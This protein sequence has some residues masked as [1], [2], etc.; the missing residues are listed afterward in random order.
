M[1]VTTEQGL[2]YHFLRTG[3]D[4]PG[5]QDMQNG[6][7][8]AVSTNKAALERVYSEQFA[9]NLHSIKWLNPSKLSYHNFLGG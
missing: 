5:W 6:R 9:W 3:H 7:Y 2:C 8:S 4:L 1:N